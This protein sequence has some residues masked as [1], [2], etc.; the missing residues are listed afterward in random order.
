MGKSKK[1]EIVLNRGGI[2]SLLKSREMEEN[3]AK[4]ARE[5]QGRCGTGYEVDTIQAG[6]RLVASVSA[7]TKEAR[8]DCMDNNTILKA[9]G[10][11]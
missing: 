4:T 6:T 1:V 11:S 7:E 2:G 9:M 8:R 5:I 10:G 3:L